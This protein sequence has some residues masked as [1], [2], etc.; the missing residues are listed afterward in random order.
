MVFN[1]GFCLTG[2]AGFAD[3]ARSDPA[4][5]LPLDCRLAPPD[6]DPAIALPSN[7]E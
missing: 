4:F 7:T 1:S 6:A 5:A 2:L 3:D